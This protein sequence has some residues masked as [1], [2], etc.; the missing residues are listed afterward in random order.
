MIGFRRQ[1]ASRMPRFRSRWIG[2]SRLSLRRVGLCAAI[3][4]VC[5]GALYGFFFARFFSLDY[6][7]VSV[8]G[9]I[10]ASRIRSVLFRQMEGR[11][12]F[13]PQK[14]MFAFDIRSAKQVLSDVFV[15]EDLSIRKELP[16]TLR[17]SVR[18]KPFRALWLTNGRLYD[19]T[20]RGTIAQ[21][22]T[23]SQIDFFPSAL[24]RRL[25]PNG[26][27]TTALG[28]PSVPYT[29]E[30]E[31]AQVPIIV[32][33]KNEPIQTEDSVFSRDQLS[34]VLALSDAI[35]QSGV[36]YDYLKTTRGSTDMRVVTN[37]GWE[38][39]TTLR[40]DPVSQMALLSKVIREKIKNNR[41]KLQYVD[42]RFG[43]RVY[44]Q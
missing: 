22:V 28:A 33:A 34:T 10:D 42:V 39:V 30:Q 31:D 9:D 41:K 14:N 24:L 17:I 20:T 25:S 5:A 44:Y 32:D 27:S 13:V 15:I 19:I 6:I 2:R 36:H 16:N 12:F 1:R 4:C 43:N 35:H 40:E 11:R 8:K 3:V 29:P 7:D 38:I 23:A 18:G 26:S 21:E 37:E